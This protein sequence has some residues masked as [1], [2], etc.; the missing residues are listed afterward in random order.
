[1]DALRQTL[2]PKDGKL[3]ITLPK[4]YTQKK[5]DVIVLPIEENLEKKSLAEKMNLLL[6]S[7][8]KN[9]PDITD[10]EILNEIKEVRKSR[11]ENGN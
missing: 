8:P 3:T 2:I 1:M 11:Y 4:D 10:E 6:S 9:E 7:L 5:F